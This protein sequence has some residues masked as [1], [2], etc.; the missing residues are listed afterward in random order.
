MRRRR[1]NVPSHEA[2][3]ATACTHDPLR[4]CAV[5]NLV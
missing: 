1:G 5:K 3:P 2:R 4:L